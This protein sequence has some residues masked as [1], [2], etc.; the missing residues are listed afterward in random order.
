MAES[1]PLTGFI[2]LMTIV[3]EQPKGLCTGTIKTGTASVNLS[4]FELD[5]SRRDDYGVAMTKPEDLTPLI[6]EFGK[7]F[8]RRMYAEMERAGTTPARA[9]LLMTLQ[10]RGCCKMSEIGSQLGV[11]GRSVTK[12]VDGLEQEGLVVRQPHPD[13]R[14]ATLIQLTA[15]GASVCKETALADRASAKLFAE[16]TATERSQLARILSKLLVRLSND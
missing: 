6:A 4:C 13:D 1:D 14:R 16:L 12:L 15:E 2:S 5:E 9:R 7:A 10:C 8:S 11:T 3:P